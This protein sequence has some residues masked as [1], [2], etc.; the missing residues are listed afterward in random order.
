MMAVQIGAGSPPQI[1][2]PKTLFKTAV[3]PT[4]NLDHYGVTSD[5]LRFLLKLPVQH[6]EQPPII[7]VTDWTAGL[8]K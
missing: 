2:T 6:R 3:V 5:G 8:K 4:F 7:V 1:G